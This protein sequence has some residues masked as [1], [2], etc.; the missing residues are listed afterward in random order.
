[1]DNELVYGDGRFEPADPLGV[2][3]VDDWT[4]RLCEKGYYPSQDV[5]NTNGLS[6]ELYEHA[7]DGWA[8]IFQTAGRC[9][10]VWCGT[11]P[12]LIGLLALVSGIALAGVLEEAD[13]S[14]GGAR[15][16]VSLPREKRRTAHTE[17]R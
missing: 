4:R 10:L 11:W 2:A 9:C 13:Y 7:E 12:D 1:M 16:P 17:G 5:G 8:V 15:L 6:Y 14:S 3:A